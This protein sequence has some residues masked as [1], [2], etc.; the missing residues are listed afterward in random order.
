[1]PRDGRHPPSTSI[2]HSEPTGDHSS[3]RTGSVKRAA[4]QELRELD[5]PV[6]AV[7]FTDDLAVG[8]VERGKHTGNAVPQI[9]VCGLRSN[10]FQNRP[11]VDFDSPVRSAM[12][13]A[14]SA[15]PCPGSIPASP[16]QHPRPGRAG[17]RAACRA[18]AH[19]SARPAAARRT[20]PASGSPTA[21]APR[22][23]PPPAYSSCLPRTAA[24]SSTSAAGRKDDRSDP[25]PDSAYGNPDPA[26]KRRFCLSVQPAPCTP[27]WP[28]RC[29]ETVGA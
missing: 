18:A 17:S 11:I 12:K 22:V 25:C 4:D 10:F 14:T 16:R 2:R 5:G 21:R 28:R 19:H 23:R 20:G 15:C 13:P 9:V 3:D 1:M 24:R 7:Q 6:T 29:G 8:D 26:V 27:P